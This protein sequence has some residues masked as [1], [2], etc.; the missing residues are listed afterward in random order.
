MSAWFWLLAGFLCLI[1]GNGRW[2]IPIAA[3]LYPFFFLR[4]THQQPIRRGYIVLTLVFM[5]GNSIAWWGTATSNPAS[6]LQVI[7]AGFGILMALIFLGERW[8]TPTINN[9][10]ANLVFPL[11][12]IT[13]EW[14]VTRFSPM[15]S[16][17]ILGYT[18]YDDLPLIQLASLTGAAGITFL[19]AW[20]GALANWVWEQQFL[21]SKVRV[22]VMLYAGVLALV[23]LYGGARLAFAT[24]PPGVTGNTIRVAG[25]TV[26]DRSLMADLD[27]ARI[28]DPAG[29]QKE[30]AE[31]ENFAFNATRREARA[32]AKVV[33]WNEVAM[34]VEHDASGV[35]SRAQALARQES[36]YLVVPLYITY[37][38]TGKLDVNKLVL[39][40]PQGEIVLDYLKFGSAALEG[41]QP[42]NQILSAVET[43]FGTLSAVIC[44]DLDFP[45]VIRQAGRNGTQVLL[46]PSFD[47]YAIDPFHSRNAVMR[48]V[49][50][51]VSLVRQ[52]A[53]G[54]SVATDA[55]GRV[56]AATDHF[57]SQER[58]IVAEVP[59]AHIPTLYAYAGDWLNWAAV[60]ALAWIIFVAARHSKGRF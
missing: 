5:V 37:P 50:N 12:Y 19:V 11:L 38:G 43:P 44:R 56:V 24:P 31:I 60:F 36:I 59:A 1:F 55:Y 8:L 32:G 26:S 3:W 58:V 40:D 30:L 13:F 52:V 57:A 42:G 39:I 27:Q 35:V 18:Q 23:L 17:G 48:A 4:F 14:L 16:I 6:P 47:W 2:A 21:W 33:L 46:A 34:F 41:I 45:E 9:G 15:G 53:D 22:W 20:F 28:K 7:P 54:Y 25:I 51:G 10:T 49:E 29:Y